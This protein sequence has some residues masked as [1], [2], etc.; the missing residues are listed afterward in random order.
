MARRISSAV[1]VDPVKATPATRGSR[2]SAAPTRAVAR[3]KLQRGRRNA[4]LAATGRTAKRRDQRRLFGGFGQH[5]VA[6]GQGRRDLA[7]EDCQRKVP[8]ADAGKDAARAGVRRWRAVGVIAQEIHRLAQFCH[9]VGQGLAGLARQKG[10]DRAE[11]RPRK[12]R[13]RGAALRRRSRAGRPRVRPAAGRCRTS[14][15]AA[16]SALAHLGRRWRD[17]APRGRRPP[18]MRPQGS[19]RPRTGRLHAGARAASIAARSA[20][21]VR[22]PALRILAPRANRSGPVRDRRDWRPG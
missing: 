4:R 6:R 12:G 10:E 8:R 13:R 17:C 15:R 22:S 18:A 21:S 1:S 19:G 3:Q 5:G 9:G 16:R 20:A 14:A 2:V 7:G 11:V